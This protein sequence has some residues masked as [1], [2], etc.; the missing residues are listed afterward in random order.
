[1]SLYGCVRVFRIQW[2]EPNRLIN[3]LYETLYSHSIQSSLARRPVQQLANRFGS[4]RPTASLVGQRFADDKCSSKLLTTECRA[5]TIRA[6]YS[7]DQVLWNSILRPLKVDFETFLIIGR[8]LISCM[9][10]NKRDVKLRCC[11][12]CC[13]LWESSDRCWK[14]IQRCLIRPTII[15]PLETSS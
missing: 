14:S 8:V 15:D 6:Q 9:P 3:D 4:Y 12:S 2:S 10:S 5:W 11:C 13:R 1:M 7:L